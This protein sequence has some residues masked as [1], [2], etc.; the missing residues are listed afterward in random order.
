M[1]AI[2]MSGDPLR[3][4]RP[5]FLVEEEAAGEE[6][7][8]V[9]DSDD[10]DDVD[11]FVFLARQPAPAEAS[12][13]GDQDAMPPRG[14]GGGGGGRKRRL[15]EMLLADDPPVAAKDKE[16][17]LS[18]AAPRGAS[19][20]GEESGSEEPAVFCPERGDLFDLGKKN[21]KRRGHGVEPKAQRAVHGKGSGGGTQH[22]DVTAEQKTPVV[23]AAAGAPRR[24]LC[25]MCGRCFG[26]HQALGGHVHLGHRKKA[27]DA[28]AAAASPE[29]VS[30]GGNGDRGEK[31]ATVGQEAADGN[32]AHGED[33]AAAGNKT[34]DFAAH[35]PDAD[36]RGFLGRNVGNIN[37][38][39]FTG[40]ANHGGHGGD[41]VVE[42]AGGNGSSA[43]AVGRPHS[44][45][46]R[47]E[48][49]GKE[50]LSGQ[51]LGGHM[52]KHRK[53]SPP[54][55]SRKERRGSPELDWIPTQRPAVTTGGQPQRERELG[56]I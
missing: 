22:R 39:I 30:G 38:E 18:L 44:K 54:D 41:E 13:D 8:Y 14:R 32:A 28:I 3:H 7:R 19:S 1:T 23:A 10:D 53:Q 49:C 16:A 46:H 42:E 26:S 17:R 56:W 55:G 50:C 20:T 45:V 36:T 12:E 51:A 33:K 6:E 21:K 9:S 37:E 24:F 2:A 29:N 34:V 47:C 4:H 27:K 31:L 11:R 40:A 5:S 25:N 15:R 52:R 35:H 48:V 43:V